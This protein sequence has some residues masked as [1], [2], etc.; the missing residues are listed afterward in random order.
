[1]QVIKVGKTVYIGTLKVAKDSTVLTKALKISGEAVTTTQYG[2]YLKAKNVGELVDVELMGQQSF[3]R[4]NLTEEEVLITK[5]LDG[6][7]AQVEKTAVKQLVNTYF[8]KA[9]GV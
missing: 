3:E 4:R 9:V 2:L 8:D 5:H 6:L 1:M 7:F